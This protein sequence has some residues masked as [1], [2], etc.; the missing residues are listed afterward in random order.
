MNCATI[1]KHDKAKSL[2]RPH[3]SAADTAQTVSVLFLTEW[4]MSYTTYPL[5]I[6]DAA[7]YGKA[8]VPSKTYLQSPAAV[9]FILAAAAAAWIRNK[10]DSCYRIHASYTIQPDTTLITDRHHTELYQTFINQNTSKY[11]LSPE[12][13][14]NHTKNSFITLSH[15]HV[16]SKCL[17]SISIRT[18]KHLE[19][20]SQNSVN[21]ASNNRRRY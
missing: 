13:C 12:C 4:V 16:S 17:S 5:K 18:Y 3:L 19:Y 8:V 9:V 15:I 7:S 11:L 21:L 10:R 2:W 14:T 1:T 20:E 6:W